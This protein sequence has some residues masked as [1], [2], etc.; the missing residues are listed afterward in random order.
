MFQGRCRLALSRIFENRVGGL[1]ARL[2]S[3]AEVQA[4][5]GEPAAQGVKI[6]M[7]LSQGIQK[8]GEIANL[9]VC[10]ALQTFDP[11]I[12]TLRQMNFKGA[13][14]PERRVD[15]DLET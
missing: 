13:V 1:L 7:A 14:G 8:P 6:I 15:G 12:P 3:R 10:R 2:F 5:I 4:V 9:A 11:G